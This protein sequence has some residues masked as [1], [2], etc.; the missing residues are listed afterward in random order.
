V[1]EFASAFAAAEL[2]GRRCKRQLAAEV[3]SRVHSAR[4]IDPALEIAKWRAPAS[5][6]GC[7]INP[8]GFAESVE[9][10]AKAAAGRRLLHCLR[11]PGGPLPPFVPPFAIEIRKNADGRA[12]CNLG[13]GFVRLPR[14]V[15]LVR[16]LGSVPSVR[17]TLE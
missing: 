17:L 15:P 12:V 11:T 13:D 10:A 2:I 7:C 9:A 14:L 16:T 8:A 4:L 6:G 5:P 3:G 1:D